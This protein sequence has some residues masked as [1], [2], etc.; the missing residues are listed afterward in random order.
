MFIVALARSPPSQVRYAFR[1]CYGR[2]LCAFSRYAS[3]CD[4]YL[5]GCCSSMV[6]LAKCSG[7]LAGGL[8]W[9][10]FRL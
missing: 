4:M 2:H 1:M 3:A 10:A 6:R 7:A 8:A 9:A 5:F